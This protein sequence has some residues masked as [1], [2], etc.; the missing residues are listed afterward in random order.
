MNTKTK[1]AFL[2]AIITV[3]LLC[4]GGLALLFAP[5]CSA[6]PGVN[7]VEVTFT[8]REMQDGSQ[9]MII[10]SSQPI[11]VVDALSQPHTHVIEK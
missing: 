10:Q 11:R 9:R 4:I 3:A 1:N 8:I 6:I 5:G 7:E 2:V